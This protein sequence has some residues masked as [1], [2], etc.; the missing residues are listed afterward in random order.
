MRHRRF[1][2]NNSTAVIQAVCA[3][4]FCLFSFIYLYFMQADIM[5]MAQHVLSGGVTHYNRLVGAILITLSLQILQAGV[6]R[7]TKL[8][9]HAH[10]LTYFPS[11][12]ALTVIT[13]IS[14]RIDFGVEWGAWLWVIP[15][16]LVLWCVVV[17]FLRNLSADVKKPSGVLSQPMWVNMLTLSVML[18]L[19]G[20]I[21]NTNAVFH[22][23]MRVEACLLDK[24]Y[25]GALG[26]GRK[27]LETDSSLTMLRAYVLAREGLLGEELFSYPVNGSGNDM[28]P[29]KQGA[30]CMM[31]PNDSI[32]RFLGAIPRGDMRTADYLKALLRSGQA[33]PA[34]KDYILCGY[35]IDKNL[36]AF[37][38]TLPSFYEINDSLPRHY[39]E[40]LTL[41]THLR[42]NPLV[43]YHNSVM[44]TDFEDL[45]TLER[46]Y[47][48]L[49]ARKK[50]VRR[51]Y[52]G[53]YWWY[54]EY[55]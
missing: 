52:S 32:Y 42:A 17:V 29:T 12:L 7:I 6:F 53:T 40:A 11:L 10:A 3:I 9:G 14:P 24:D 33:T 39:R 38:K 30:H 47:S 2:M 45:Q 21:G 25:R 19:V 23:R 27:S 28:V 35:L 31:Y 26:V 46:Q 43:V 44:D 13:D 36:D 15:L 54:Y 51:Q 37:A 50:A 4:I 55:E 49:E 20:A 8:Y 34:V 1:D 41:Y 18:L 22:Y 48:T 5:A 16:A